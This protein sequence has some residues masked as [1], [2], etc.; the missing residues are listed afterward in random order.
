MKCFSFEERYQLKDSRRSSIQI[1]INIKETTYRDITVKL[2]NP[3]RNNIVRMVRERGLIKGRVVIWS[4]RTKHYP[5]LPIRVGA[6]VG[7]ESMCFGTGPIYMDLI[8]LQIHPVVIYGI[9]KHSN[10][11]NTHVVVR[12]LSDGNYEGQVEA[13]RTASSY[14]HSKPRAKLHSWGSQTL[15]H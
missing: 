4:W 7:Q 3:K 1:N 2:G 12:L 15:G 9:D 5:S 11:Q 6:Y 10:W 14:Q 13:T 8:S